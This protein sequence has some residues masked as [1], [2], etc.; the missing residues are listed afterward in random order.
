MKLCP[1]TQ[2]LQFA[3]SGCGGRIQNCIKNLGTVTTD[4]S[5]Q[6]EM[7]RTSSEG[8]GR[9][10]IQNWIME[11][12]PSANW[13][14]HR[15]EDPSSD[16]QNLHKKLACEVTCILNAVAERTETGLEV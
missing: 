6:S 5:L 4:I 9:K 12:A 13:L 16:P 11:M 10:M 14:R 1:F 3:G 7:L 15:M 8:G 2:A